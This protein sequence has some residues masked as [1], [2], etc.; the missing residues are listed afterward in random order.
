M[1][2]AAAA[3][4]DMT[5]DLMPS[6]DQTAIAAAAAS[7]LTGRLPMTRVRE[8]I[9]RADPVD[10]AAWLAVAD[11]GWFGLGLAEADGGIGYGLAEE[12]MLFREI[13]RSLVP[14]P[15]LST[16]LGARV[17]VDG[18]ASDI[19]S[20]VLAGGARVGLVLGGIEGRVRIAVPDGLD[21]GE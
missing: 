11:L 9:D 2:Q 10:A 3:R 18:G 6:E 15:F 16:V 7:F 1:S 13:G 19:A 20:A 5:M 8:L 12:A 17:A 4:N 14:G 21:Q